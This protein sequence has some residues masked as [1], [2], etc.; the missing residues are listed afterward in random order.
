[1]TTNDIEKIQIILCCKNG[2]KLLGVTS[3]KFLLNHIVGFVQFV[4]VDS[5]KF[6][7]LSIKELLEDKS[8]NVK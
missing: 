1:M 6:W 3:D 2:E 7:E 5:S 4:Q 8:T